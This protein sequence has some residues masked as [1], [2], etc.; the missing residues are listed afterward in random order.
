M[1]TTIQQAI[2]KAAP[3]LAA[4]LSTPFPRKPFLD[5]VIVRETPLAEIYEASNL[6]LPL[7]DARRKDRSDRGI[8]V[9]VGDFVPMGGVVLPMPVKVDAEVY[10]D[11]YALT[12]PV[13]LLPSD[14]YRHDLPR[15]WQIRVGDLKGEKV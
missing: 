11:E 9:A 2:E 8:V 6:E 13:Y 14:K 15:Y 12:D 4:A 7:D 3:Q 10:F 5:R 1:S